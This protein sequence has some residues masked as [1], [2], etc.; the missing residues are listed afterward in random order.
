[1]RVATDVKITT[2]VTSNKD[3]PSAKYNPVIMRVVS[4]GQDEREHYIHS[5]YLLPGICVLSGGVSSLECV[6]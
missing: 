6:L 2:V 1:M 4:F 3:S 5:E